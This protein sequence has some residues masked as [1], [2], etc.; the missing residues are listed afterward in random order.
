[1]IES[2]LNSR[3][4][5]LA[6]VVRDVEDPRGWRVVWLHGSDA[7]QSS[8][9]QFTD[10]QIGDEIWWETSSHREWAALAGQAGLTHRREGRMIQRWTLFI[11]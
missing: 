4:R 1:M 9:H 10:L 2:H 7:H 11:S 5:C 6:C 3:S 8:E